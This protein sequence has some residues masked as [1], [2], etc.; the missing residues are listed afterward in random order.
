MK[1]AKWIMALFVGMLGAGATRGQFFFNNAVAVS[2]F[3]AAR[4]ASFVRFGPR[5]A[6]ATVHYRWYF[7]TYYYPYSY[8]DYPYFGSG[9]YYSNPSIVI[10]A[11]APIAAPRRQQEEEVPK[12]KLIILPRKEE[13][14]DKPEAPLP[15]KDAGVFRPVQ[16]A[17]RARALQPLPP[18]PRKLP[19]VIPQP[20]ARPPDIPPVPV[21]L[22]SR[23]KQAF[24][25]Q[26]YGRAERLFQ[27]AASNEPQS[28]LPHFL[29]AQARFALDKYQEATDAVLT[30][31]RLQAD[32]PKSK[33]RPEDLYASHRTD[34]QEQF[35]HL[36]EV[37][38]RKPSDPVLLNLYAYQ[39]WFTGRVEEAKPLFRRAAEISLDKTWTDLFMPA[40]PQ[41]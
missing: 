6:F 4:S 31:L 15:G 37:L 40:S 28:H 23:G 9:A 16:P 14:A 32:W 13:A 7:P 27:Q 11:P 5:P 39:L 30:G 20:E 8:W 24:A 10:N 33:Y 36:K 38:D 18:E 1:S 29:L 26:E 3:G 21:D 19:E 12:G 22:V 17:D 35:D 34:F 2:P 25:A 41:N